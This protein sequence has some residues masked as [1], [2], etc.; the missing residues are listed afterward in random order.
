M[1]KIKNLLKRLLRH[2]SEY[3]YVSDQ[4]DLR[5]TVKVYN[6]DNLIM[7]KCTK[8]DHH[9][10]IINSNAKFILKDYSA[11]SVNLTVVTGNHPQFPGRYYQT[12]SK[13]KEG[14]DYKLYDKDVVVEND[15]WIGC[16]VTLLSG[17]HIG[18]SAV[19][20]AGA[21]VSKDI[22]PYCI[23]GGVPAKVIKIKWSIDEIL[24][25]ESC[26]YPESERYSREEIEEL[27][28]KYGKGNG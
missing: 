17:V 6:P 15:V 24:Y 23:A 3:K 14:I 21:V 1:K 5:S 11:A 7:G 8:I 4:A 13:K 19:I 12:I 2:K 20:A 27:F 25:H 16:N 22:P 9:S 28:R 10:I 18:R 26:L